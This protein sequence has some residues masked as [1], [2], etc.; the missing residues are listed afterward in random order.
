[1][2]ERRRDNTQIDW[3]EIAPHIPRDAEGAAA[4][5]SGVVGNANYNR[6]RRGISLLP[7]PAEV[8]TQPTETQ[9]Q[10]APLPPAEQ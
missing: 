5:L 9:A 7:L 1:M 3:G 4:F 10:P 6:A 8:V 2:P